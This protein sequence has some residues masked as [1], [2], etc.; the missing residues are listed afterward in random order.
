MIIQVALVN[1]CIIF[2]YIIFSGNRGVKILKH[3]LNHTLRSCMCS[4]SG[5]KERVYKNSKLNLRYKIGR[6]KRMM[7]YE[8]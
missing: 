3:K 7:I 6:K 4:M 2:N 8:E 5:K 1:P